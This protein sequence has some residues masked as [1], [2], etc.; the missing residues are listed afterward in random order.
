MRYLA[1]MMSRPVLKL[2]EINPLLFNFVEE[3]VEIRVGGFPFYCDTGLACKK[4][5]ELCFIYFFPP[6][7]YL[8]LCDLFVYGNQKCVLVSVAVSSQ[9]LRQ[10]ILL[11]KP[12]FITCKEAM[13]ARLL[14][15]VSITLRAT[16]LWLWVLKVC[17]IVLCTELIWFVIEEYYAATAQTCD[18]NVWNAFLKVPLFNFI[19]C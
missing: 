17:I 1:L 7:C 16:S 6:L 9:K 3:L 8:C 19:C 14:L 12:Y 13:E 2:K 10:D 4:I 11:M 15:Q 5:M 18:E